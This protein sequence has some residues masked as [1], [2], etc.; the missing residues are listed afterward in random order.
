MSIFVQWCCSTLVQK[1]KQ[2]SAVR[3]KQKT[4][5]LFQAFF[6]ARS[7][8]GNKPLKRFRGFQ[9]SERFRRIDSVVIDSAVLKRRV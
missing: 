9:T 6:H 3:C 7:E 8:L 4:T 5:E 1:C 2:R